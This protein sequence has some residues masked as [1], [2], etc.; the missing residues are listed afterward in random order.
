[1]PSEVILEH[2]EM[3]T[4]LVPIT[5]TLMEPQACHD[6]VLYL[7]KRF[8]IKHMCVGYALAADLS[9]RYH[10]WGLGHA[11]NI[12]ET[13]APFLAYFGCLLVPTEDIHQQHSF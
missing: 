13:T 11:D 8:K 10:S 4:P 3:F 9:W 2:G 1:M 5:Y 6:N 12:V 7:Y